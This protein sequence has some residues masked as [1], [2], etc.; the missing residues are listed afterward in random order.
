MS[1]G[2]MVSEQSQSQRLHICMKCL[3]EANLL[4]HKV[5]DQLPS[6]GGW[7]GRGLGVAADGYRVSSTE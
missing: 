1:L 4:R 7:N 5:D 3:E 6:T 2:N